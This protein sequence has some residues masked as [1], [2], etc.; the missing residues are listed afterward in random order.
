LSGNRDRMR[1]E[2][3]RP[4]NTHT[5]ACRLLIFR[6]EALPS[7]EDDFRRAITFGTARRLIGR[8]QICGLEKST[9]S[10]RSAPR[11]IFP[12]VNTKYLN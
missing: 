9:S 2:G 3:I 12:G 11:K 6:A 8:R 7:G 5:G 1:V 10:D 4:F